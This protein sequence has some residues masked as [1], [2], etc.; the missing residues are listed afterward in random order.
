MNFFSSMRATQDE[1]LTL[2]KRAESE[3]LKI[4]GAYREDNIIFEKRNMHF[5]TVGKVFEDILS[6]HF[7]KKIY[8][9]TRSL[10]TV[11]GTFKKAS[12]D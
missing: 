1:I 7:G 10:K 9:T 4:I 3:D 6:N 12:S 8:V 2:L 11:E 5:A